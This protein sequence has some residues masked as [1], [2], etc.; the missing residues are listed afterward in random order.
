M[1]TQA[2]TNQRQDF[3]K[4]PNNSDF[5]ITEQDEYAP[6][7]NVQGLNGGCGIGRRGKPGG[8]LTAQFEFIMH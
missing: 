1:R 5:A 3:L 8:S 2:P 7:S 4:G 6:F